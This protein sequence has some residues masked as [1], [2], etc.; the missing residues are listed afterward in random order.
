[1]VTWR[2]RVSEILRG[3]FVQRVV[4]TKALAQATKDKA[5]AAQEAATPA[6]AAQGAFGVQVPHE[7]C[8]RIESEILELRTQVDRL[9]AKGAQ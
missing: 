4:A 9:L 2:E 3:P 1:M 7:W 8:A 6:Q 5:Q